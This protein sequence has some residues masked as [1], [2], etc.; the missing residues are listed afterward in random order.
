ML[1]GYAFF[2]STTCN[3]EFNHTIC[4]GEKTNNMCMDV[5][6]EYNI[7]ESYSLEK[8]NINPISFEIKVLQ[9]FEFAD[10]KFFPE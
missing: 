10:I 2:I 6:L 5:F 9:S 1:K 7:I 3:L 8:L 4:K